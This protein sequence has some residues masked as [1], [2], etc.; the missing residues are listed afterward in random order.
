M[1]TIRTYFRM[2]MEKKVIKGNCQPSLRFFN[3]R[4]KCFQDSIWEELEMGMW[5]QYN[6]DGFMV[7]ETIGNDHPE[8]WESVF[9]YII[10]IIPGYQWNVNKSQL[11]LN[12]YHPRKLD[13][14]SINTFLKTS[15]MFFDKYRN[16]KI[17]VHLSGGLDSTLIIC[18]LKHFNIPFVLGGLEV[19]R[20]EMR[21]ERYIQQKIREYGETSFLIGLEETPYFSGLECVP[22]HQ[23][24]DEHIRGNEADRALADAFQREG[25]EVVFSG[26]GGDSLLMENEKDCFAQ[27]NIGFEFQLPWSQDHFYGPRGIELVSFYADERV[28]DQISNLRLGQNE[29][30]AK[31]WA[32]HFFRDFLPKELSDF[33]Y[34]GDYF[35]LTLDGLERAKPTIKLLL[36]EAYDLTHH[37]YFSSRQVERTLKANVY[38]FEIKEYLEFCSR[39]SIAVWLHSL[40]RDNCI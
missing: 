26:Q 27:Y 14:V 22:K 18:L 5:Q 11:E 40:F 33:C 30:P 32:R 6:I 23:V 7:N 38:T 1:D 10:P 3:H 13:F 29:D 2:V 24:P 28:V 12:L 25:V 19:K 39:I 36:E 20:F 35:G 21:T 34:V 31:L 16:K 37:K 4:E 8:L 17:G 15:E 9:P